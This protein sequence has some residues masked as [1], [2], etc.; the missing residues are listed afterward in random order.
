MAENVNTAV[1]PSITPLAQTAKHQSESPQIQ[2]VTKLKK[3]E[4]DLDQIAED[5]MKTRIFT[6]PAAIY[7]IY[8]FWNKWFATCT[9]I[10][11]H[12]C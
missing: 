12:T 5:L 1:V 10:V 2:E 6:W 3:Y 4:L 8:G 9:A 11:D 7:A